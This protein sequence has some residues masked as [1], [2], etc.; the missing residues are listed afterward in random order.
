[1]KRWKS[2]GRIS[3]RKSFARYNLYFRKAMF[4]SRW[5]P[6]DIPLSKDD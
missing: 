3:R 4:V 2:L 6:M 1:M 5:S